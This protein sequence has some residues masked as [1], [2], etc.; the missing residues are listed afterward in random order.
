MIK[1]NEVTK[2]SMIAAVVL[3]VAT[4]SIAFYLGSA[5]QKAKSQSLTLSEDAKEQF[6]QDPDDIENPFP[7]QKENYPGEATGETELFRGEITEYRSDC[8]FDSICSF[9]VDGKEI[10]TVVGWSQETRGHLDDVQVGDY[11]EVYAGKQG[12]GYTLY[13]S[14][15]YYIRFTK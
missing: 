10:V 15:D 4:F 14:D 3:Y 9:T 5:W 13:G 2:T 12:N 11:V 8:A 1:L 7:V 6:L